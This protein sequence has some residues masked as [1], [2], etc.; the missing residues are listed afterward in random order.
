M[1]YHELTDEIAFKLLAFGKQA[2][3]ET[4][5]GDKP[6][7]PQSL[8]DLFNLIA[9]Y[10]LK[11]YIGYTKNKNGDITGAFLG[12]ISTEYFSG[13]TIAND[14]GMFVAPAYRGSS[15]FVRLLKDF[16]GWAKEMGVKKIILY[17]STGIEP[18]KT[19]KLF[20]KLDYTMF[21]TIFDKEI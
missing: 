10:P 1:I 14:L 6:Y 3:K 9:T 11:F 8:Y 18:E 4:R 12:Q 15:V 5:Y 13:T 17:H 2:H 16:E 20:T 21:G 19:N 7:N